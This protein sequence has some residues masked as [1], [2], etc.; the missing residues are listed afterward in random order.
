MVIN[1]GSPWDVGHCSKEHLQRLSPG[2][3]PHSF[4]VDLGPPLDFSAK[5]E[6]HANSYGLMINFDMFIDNGE[7]AS[8]SQ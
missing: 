5:M 7:Q 6:L 2:L 1:R 3:A 4:P 8:I